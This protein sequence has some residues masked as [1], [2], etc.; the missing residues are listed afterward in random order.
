MPNETLKLGKF[1]LL[2]TITRDLYD[3]LSPTESYFRGMYRLPKI[4]KDG[5]PFRPILSALKSF[6]FDLTKY[7]IAI[8]NPYP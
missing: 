6:N 5:I 1:R 8:L 2:K 7:L 3:R 4:H